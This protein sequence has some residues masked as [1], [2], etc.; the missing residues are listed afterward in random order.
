MFRVLGA[1]V[2]GGFVLVAWSTLFGVL[3]PVVSQGSWGS[4]G[5]NASAVAE[6]VGDQLAEFGRRL[7]F[8]PSEARAASAASVEPVADASSAAPIDVTAMVRGLGVA[9]AAGIF[10]AVLMSL[11]GGKRRSFAE[12]VLFAVLLGAFAGSAMLLPA[13]G[14]ADFSLSRS[15]PLLGEVL[16]GWLLAGLVIAVILGGKPLRKKAK[17]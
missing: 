2:V 3:G 10:A 7:P 4:D 1:G 12:R 13:G 11:Y 16:V 9:C 8:G 14:W 17:T 5:V 15:A 6:S